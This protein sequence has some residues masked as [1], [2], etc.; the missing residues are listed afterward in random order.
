MNSVYINGISTVAPHQPFAVEAAGNSGER[1]SYLQVRKPEYRKYIE[2]KAMRRMSKIVRMGIVAAKEALQDSSVEQP[3]AIVTG[4]GMGCQA[5]TEK[6]L[7]SMINNKETLLNP[8]A[9]IQ[10]THNTIGA[11]VALILGNTNYNMTYVHRTF[12]FESA[13]L[14]SLM[15]ISEGEAVNVLV[16]GVDEIT[17]ESHLIKTRIGYYKKEPVRD[18]DFYHD[19]QPGAVAGESA[20]FFVLSSQKND[21]SY[22]SVDGIS[23][24]YRPSG[25][26][27]TAEKVR[28]FLKENHLTVEDVDFVLMGYNGDTEFDGIYDQLVGDLFARNTIIRYKHLCGEHDAS[29]AFATCVAAKLFREKVIP[30][31]MLKRGQGTVPGKNILIYNQ[32]RNINHSLILLGRP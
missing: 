21:H 31:L 5:D 20:S 29:S 10:S 24:F 28:Y 3:D 27:E 25:R 1:L 22:A 7:N 4:T 19:K 16:G 8:T 12:S 18:G 6:F 23:T 17:E 32:F 15:L 14:D 2:P 9:F 30:G 13:L 11:Q 26:E